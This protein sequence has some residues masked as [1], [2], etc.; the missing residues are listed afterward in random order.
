[1][2]PDLNDSVQEIDELARWLSAISSEIPLH[3]SRFFPNYLMADKG[4]TPVETLK[5]A[6]SQALKY[7]KHARN[8]LSKC[9][10]D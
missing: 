1:M 10:Y 4:P 7:L 8:T 2:I 6:R 5:A 9:L 3:L